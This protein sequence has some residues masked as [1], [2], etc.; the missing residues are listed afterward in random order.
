MAR[1]QGRDVAA[2]S[3]RP[4]GAPP[5][6][7]WNT[8]I[9][10]SS[11]DEAAAKTRQAGGRVMTDPF[12]VMNAGRM[13]VLAD[14]EGAVFSVW[15]AKDHTGARIVNEPGSVVFNN[16]NTRD[17]QAAK[18]FYGAVFGWTTIEL[19]GGE[20]WTL[21]GY[22]DQLEERDPGLRERIASMGVAAGFADVVAA[23]TPIAGDQPDVPAHWSVTFSVQDAEM[24]ATRATELG[25]TVLVAPRDAPWVRMTVLRDPQGAT[26]IASRFA[27]E[28]R[29]LA[30]DA[31]PAVDAA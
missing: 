26:F 23:I 19:G 20:G 6:A 1:L 25:G 16:L 11:A 14:P 21:P 15:Q 13:A 17:A 2:V 27:P 31:G 24:T 30:Q 18:R 8:Y 4:E 10:V 7:V 12:D 9:S 22:G 28:N 29:D 3:S 5:A